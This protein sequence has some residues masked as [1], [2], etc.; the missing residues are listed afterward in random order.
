MSPMLPPNLR[1]AL[2]SHPGPTCLAVKAAS[3]ETVLVAKLAQADL[4]RLHGATTISYR[5]EVGMYPEGSCFRIVVAFFDAGVEMDCFID[6][7]AAEQ[8]A[9][10]ERLAGQA[11]L[12]FHLYDEALVYAF[13][14]RIN[15]PA[16][17]RKQIERLL[18]IAWGYE[19]E[20]AARREPSD[21]LAAKAQM[22]RDR[23]MPDGD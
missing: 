1:E 3:G 16:L 20:R 21:F 23:P 17:E 22:M 9:L 2:A 10:V 6:A 4:A 15:H 14:K 11:T 5:V 13:S 7:L 18:V 12:D 19:S 8:R